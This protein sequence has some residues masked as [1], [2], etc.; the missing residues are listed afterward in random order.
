MATL[1]SDEIF[2]GIVCGCEEETLAVGRRLGNILPPRTI[3]SLDGPL[4]AGKTCFVRGLAEGLGMEPSGVSSP[5]FPLIHEYQGGRLPLIH[6]DLYR[7]GSEAELATI[8]L[9]DLL[10]EPIIAAIEWGGKF[11]S[12]LP[13][14]TWRVEFLIEGESR[15]IRASV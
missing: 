15:R 1:L 7:I 8:G 4:G 6:C 5:T 11:P 9:D 3:L 13:P 12:A 2:T 10:S 14:G